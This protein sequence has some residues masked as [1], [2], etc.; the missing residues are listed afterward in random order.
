MV[1]ILIFFIV[2]NAFA[3]KEKSACNCLFLGLVAWFI[4][5]TPIYLYLRV[6]FNVAFNIVLLL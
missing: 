4:I 6:Y 1:G 2:Q 3:K 5:N